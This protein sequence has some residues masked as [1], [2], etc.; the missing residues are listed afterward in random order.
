MVENPI[1]DYRELKFLGSG[2]FGEAFLVEHIAT[3]V[4]YNWLSMQTS[5]ETICSE[6]AEAS[7]FG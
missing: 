7:G 4:K 1:G 6:K 2:S 3:K 5:L